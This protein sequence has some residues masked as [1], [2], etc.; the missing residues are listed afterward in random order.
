M[1]RKR[2]LRL[3]I[4]LLASFAILFYFLL[5]PVF[6]DSAGQKLTGLQYADQLFNELSKGSSYFIPAA[7]IAARSVSGKT[8][9]LNVPLGSETLVPVAEKLLAGADAS[10]IRSRDGHMIFR[11]DLSRLLSAATDDSALLYD[12]DGAALRQKYGFPPLEVASAWWHLLEPCI[13][14]LQKRKLN[15]EAAA[16]ETVTRRAI[17]PGNNFYGITARKVA[18]NI[19]LLCAFLLFYVIYTVWYGFA[20]YEVFD[21][22]GL[23]NAQVEEIETECEER[24]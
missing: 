10:N 11:A 12:N 3:G 24:D 20:I 18:D 7:Q 8:A 21:G 15:S 14:A 9:A 19:P 6:K 13:H 16:V 4:S 23:M 1:T 5:T 2:K 17:E 22:L